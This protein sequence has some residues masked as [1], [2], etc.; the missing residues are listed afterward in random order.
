[1]S[2]RIDCPVDHRRRHQR[3]GLDVRDA[4]VD[5]SAR[6]LSA[7][8]STRRRISCATTSACASTATRPATTRWSRRSMRSRSARIPHAGRRR[9]AAHVLRIRH[10]RGAA[11]CS[12]ARASTRWCSRWASAGGSTR[13]TSI[14]ADVAV[15]DERSTSITSTISARRARPSAARRPASSARDGRAVCGDRESAASVARRTPPRLGAPLLA[16][17]PRL[18]RTPTRARSGAIAV[19][20][21][22]RFGLPLPALRG[23]YQLGNAATALAALDAL[24]ERLPVA[25]RRSARGLVHVE[26]AGRF[27]V[28]PGRPAIVLDV[29]HNPQAARA[30][31]DALGDMGSH[32]RTLAVFGDAGRQGHRRRRRA[33]SRRASTAGT[34]RR[35]RAR[36]AQRRRA[37]QTRSRRPVSPPRAIRAFDDIAEAF[38][39]ARDAASEADRIVGL[40]LVPHRRCGAR[41]GRR[42][43]GERR[44][45]A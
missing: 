6:R 12:R 31:A 14:D 26:L 28:L 23:A 18:R 7:P 9:Y 29:A 21:G 39:A 4:R 13:S 38:D 27:Q 3:Q 42:S 5:P 10:A 30:L 20:R 33:R 2:L 34:S 17:R 16:P 32:P 19:P 15:R 8:A 41:R 45:L 24:R 44:N 1:M 36:A 22:E 11:G 40:R 43:G 35:C 25:R 37:S